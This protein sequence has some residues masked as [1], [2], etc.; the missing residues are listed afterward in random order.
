M[1]LPESSHEKEGRRND[2]LWN[3]QKYSIQTI[4]RKSFIMTY[5]VFKTLDLISKFKRIIVSKTFLY[6][7]ECLREFKIN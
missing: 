7:Y 6:S 1:K 3:V 2:K 4:H 5:Y